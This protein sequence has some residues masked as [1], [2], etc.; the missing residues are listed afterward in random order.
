MTNMMSSAIMSRMPPAAIIRWASVN[1]SARRTATSPHTP[2]PPN[3]PMTN[4][5][6]MTRMGKFKTVYRCCAAA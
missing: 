4:S 5:A 2:I 1:L 6:S 3:A